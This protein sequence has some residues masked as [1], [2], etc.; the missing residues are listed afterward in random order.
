MSSE[1]RVA[2]EWPALSDR[3]LRD[4]RSSR[5]RP[6]GCDN[7]FAAPARRTPRRK[8]ARAPQKRAPRGETKPAYQNSV[9]ERRRIRTE[10][11]KGKRIA[12][13]GI[14]VVA[15]RAQ[16]TRERHLATI[17]ATFGSRN[18]HD[19]HFTVAAR[20]TIENDGSA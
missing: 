19:R 2:A 7:M 18:H 14:E 1:A 8:P 4:R 9:N 6:R 5:R 20:G 16:R 15:Q 17:A 12:C 10:C 11:P 13:A 3:R